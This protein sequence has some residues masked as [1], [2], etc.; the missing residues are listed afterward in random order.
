MGTIA[1]KLQKMIDNKQLIVDSVNSKAGT[2]FDLDSKLSDVAEA[3]QNISTGSSENLLQKQVDD[4]GARGLFAH[5]PNANLDEYINSID[6][7]NVTDTYL[8][9]YSCSSLTSIPLFNTSKVTNMNQMFYQCY[10]LKS[11]PQFDT[12]NAIDTGYMFGS[13]SSL[14]NIPQL[15]TSSAT[16]MY[17]M[18]GG[19][20]SLTKIPQLDT[21]KSNRM[22]GM[23]N[24]CSKLTNIDI[25]YYNI[26]STTYSANFAYSCSALKSLIIRG[27]SENYVLSSNSFIGS[28]IEN[29]TGY[30][31]VPRAMVD[32]L[33]SATNWSTYAS[34]IKPIF[35]YEC[36]GDGIINET[37]NNENE[38]ILTANG[39]DFAGWYKG[40]IIESDVKKT[41]YNA[42]D[43]TYPFVLNENKYY[44]NTNQS[45]N[46]SFSIGRFYFDIENEKQKLKITYLQ[47]SE[48]NYDYGIIGKVDISLTLDRYEID[49]YMNLK[50]ITA[51][52]PTEIIIDNVSVGSHFIDIKYIKDSSSSSGT[53][54]LQVKVEVS[55]GEFRNVIDGELYSSEPEINLGVINEKTMDITNL[56]AKFGGTEDV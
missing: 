7:S 32:T 10:N 44:Q 27:F 34:Q 56:I 46:S 47:S 11:V 43:V 4:N 16:T 19:C 36:F 3:I 14:T 28:G 17:Y 22:N 52:T 29:G 6:T 21:S 53:D 40:N 31:Y 20:S 25:T 49:S 2:S 5:W 39:E 42:L 37:I 54:T 30:I 51:T 38:T 18:F 9:F 13:C 45:I 55:T 15:D 8:M 35:N 33:K 48:K 41:T 12:S 1:E 23:F 26:S 50:G 24:N